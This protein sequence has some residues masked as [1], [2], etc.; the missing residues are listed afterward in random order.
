MV[1]LLGGICTK[2]EDKEK[3]QLIR[4]LN[5]LSYQINEL[6]AQ[7]AQQ[8]TLKSI[9]RQERDRAQKYLDIAD[10]IFIIVNPNQMVAL[11]NKKGCEI[12][13]YEKEEDILDQNW[14]DYFL[15][16]RIREDVRTIFDQ[17]MAGE[18]EPVEYFEN[19]V[20]TKQGREKIISW[21]NTILTDETGKIIGTLSSGEDI[22]ERK[23]AEE[24]L[25]ASEEKYRT[26]VEQNLLGI[27]IL[28]DGRFVFVNQALA[29]MSGFTV[30]ELLKLSPDEVQTLVHL[31]DRPLVFSR[32]ED[33]L[34]G[35][36]VPAQYQYRGVR[37]NGSVF[38]VEAAVTL[39]EYK[40]RPAVQATI[41]DITEQKKFEE[42]LRESEE[43]YRTL[44]EKSLQGILIFQNDRIVFAHAP[45][46]QITDY[47]LKEM[48]GLSFNEFQVIIH[49]E[50]RA[51]AAK[52]FKER[53]T[54]NLEPSAYEYRGL[55]KDGTIYW[56]EVASNVIQYQGDPAVQVVFKNITERKQAEQLLRI[57]RDLGIIFNS[58]TNLVNAFNRLLEV[59][60]SME[61]LDFGG[62]YLVNR[63]TG[64]LDL[65]AHK[66]LSQ[67]FIKRVSHYD[68]DHPQT[69]LVMAG[70]PIYK[71]HRKIV[72]PLEMDEVRLREG[73]RALAV[74]PILHE[75]KVVGAL[76]IASRTYDE[77]SSNIR[78]GLET[79]AS[80]TG[81]F[82]VRLKTE[83]ALRESEYKFRRFVEQSLDGIVLTNE[84]GIIT[85][86]SLGMERIIGLKANQ[87]L[88]RS[89]C[90][91]QFEVGSNETPEQYKRI[92]ILIH[93]L[94]KTD[95]GIAN[96]LNEYEVFHTNG[97][98]HFL[99]SLFFPIKTQKGHMLG[100][101]S[102]DI[103][104]HKQAAEALQESE[105]KYRALVEESLQGVL[106]VQD[107]RLVF[108]NGPLGK[109]MGYTVKEL[110]EWSLEDIR[111]AIHPEDQA[112][113]IENLKALFEGKS[114][115]QRYE[116]R[117]IRKDRKIFWAEIFSTL[118]EYQGKPAVQATLIDIT[119]RK[120][121]EEKLQNYQ[122]H[123]E[124]LVEQRTE[125][126]TRT[127]EQLQNE[128]IIRKQAEEQIKNSLREK[129]ILLQEIH[130]RVKNN[131]QIISSII[132]LQAR[133][134]K[135][136][137]IFE[138]FKDIQNRVGSMALIHEKLYH[139]KDLT[140]I[141]VVDYIQTLTTRLARSSG[142]YTVRL[143]T[144]IDDINL[145]IDTTIYCGL[146]INE[147]VSNALKH[148]FADGN[149]GEILVKLSQEDE[150]IV[151]IVSDTGVGFPEDLDLQTTDT[152]G[153]Q[154]V[155][156]LADQLRGTVELNTKNRTTFKV[157][158]PEKISNTDA[159]AILE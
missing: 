30:E 134:I 146:I 137:P 46:K 157:I 102:R 147:L 26:L 9:L 42:N 87:V 86:W 111:A 13:G 18:I 127:N 37:K 106:I 6:K 56:V 94:L 141:D 15:P 125:E 52:R 107:N 60:L 45:N 36:P 65:V 101:I 77:I 49:P 159:D 148:A 113:V 23:Q 44:I 71:L 64:A 152:L 75:E 1:S 61:G 8:D 100:I 121:V 116:L 81:A 10:V 80:Q 105:E 62:V 119:E 136:H 139:S 79:I 82:I 108:A 97:T 153:L 133:S 122:E 38:W 17:L 78:H 39:V 70:N 126:L 54:G 22:T 91:V 138:L 7:Q 32:M 99:Q 128:I 149:S 76:N 29:K 151:L 58:S 158:F 156:T 24:I 12:L 145:D 129:E 98:K 19:P 67:Q 132:T 95:K 20:L 112:F 110:M 140:K 16:E 51:M 50:D 34:E 131:L 130:H 85:E 124:E 57:Q 109:I 31:E 66:G 5:E 117:G 89:F 14:F 142:V 48:I 144:E 59:I 2:G 150:N 40:D 25:R 123:L 118:I 143:K 155:L 28:Q 43:K 135:G 96:N 35:K 63:S 93:D 74:I 4:E 88:G 84:Q 69:Q 90:D 114:I 3:D 73:L 21:H 47:N 115:P 33:R 68:V 41:L 72:P 53:L 103:T 120:Q 154:L 55:R 27:M 92:K 11:I 104:I 83:E